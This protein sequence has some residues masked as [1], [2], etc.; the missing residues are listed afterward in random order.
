MKL[1][2][3][4]TSTRPSLSQ[5]IDHC[6]RRVLADI[7]LTVSLVL[8]CT[9]LQ[10]NPDRLIDFDI[11]RQ[12]ADR[13]L[14]EFAA[15]A[16]VTLVFPYDDAAKVTTNRLLGRFTL[17]EGLERL[18]QGTPLA[19]SM[20]D[21]QLSVVL[22]NNQEETT[23][24]TSFFGRLLAA[25]TL[26]STATSGAQAQPAGDSGMQPLEEII[27]TARK[28]D[29]SLLEVPMSLSVLSGDDLANIGVSNFQQLSGSVPGLNY[30][31]TFGLQNR[32]SMRGVGATE[33]T[34]V[35]PGVGLFIDGVFQP[36]Q[37]FFGIGFQ[38][39]ERLEILR[40]PQGTLY[41]RNTLAGAINIITAEPTNEFTGE[42][43]L[44]VGN[45]DTYG[46]SGFLS[47]AIIDEV[48]KFRLSGFYKES[49]GFWDSQATGDTL[50][51]Y[52]KQGARFKLYYTPN[53]FFDSRLSMTYFD[54]DASW[55]G[56]S[57][58]DVSDSNY[59][60]DIQMTFSSDDIETKS[61]AL[62]LNFHFESFDVI[63]I[64]SYDENETFAELDAVL[65]DAA[66]EG[67]QFNATNDTDSFGQELRIQSTGDSS[68]QWLGG[69]FYNKE[70]PDLGGAIG[71]DPVP[72][73]EE[74]NETV[75]FFV[76]GDYRLSEQ[77]EVGAGLRYDEVDRERLD[78]E[79]GS[80]QR[81]HLRRMAAP[82]H[83]APLPLRRHHDLWAGR[84]GVPARRFQRSQQF[85][86]GF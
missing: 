48:L 45:E 23:V 67:V 5:L 42:V 41:G 38:D 17:T 61:A 68:L 58:P 7:T 16:N 73:N 55:P 77:W 18:L 53:E 69:V 64:S 14:I 49:D 39:V 22:A 71:S 81:R 85:T 40:G 56:H 54:Q 52:E 33:L 27:V 62:T 60:D 34:N 50:S 66:L 11:A 46:A 8:G 84:Q 10:A 76:D 19:T 31:Q 74:E 47:G 9:Q 70:E 51:D 35:T 83:T 26:G 32:I 72:T 78:L 13:S 59:P 57:D 25:L 36:N 43:E 63:S 37:S 65:V 12:S 30:S 80:T 75:A 4:K 28:R 24:K 82:G 1:M 79:T 2:W 86:T 20:T 3:G 15:Q 21:G 44:E 6:A 29:E